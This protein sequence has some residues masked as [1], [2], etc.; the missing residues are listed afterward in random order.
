MEELEVVRNI[1]V[2]NNNDQTGTAEDYSPCVPEYNDQTMSTVK[3][4]YC[5]IGYTRST[6]KMLM[7][8]PYLLHRQLHYIH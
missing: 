4:T 1:K 5:R 2:N 6:K 3:R 7:V 8:T